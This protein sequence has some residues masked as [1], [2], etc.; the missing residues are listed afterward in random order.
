MCV[1]TQLP[2]DPGS[3]A[4]APGVSCPDRHNSTDVQVLLLHQIEQLASVWGALPEQIHAP[5]QGLLSACSHGPPGVIPLKCSRTYTAHST[6]LL[7]LWSPTYA[8]Q[9]WSVQSAYAWTQ[10]HCSVTQTAEAMGGVAVLQVAECMHLR[11]ASTQHRSSPGCWHSSCGITH[12]HS[13]CHDATRV[14]SSRHLVAYI[15]PH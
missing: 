8:V 9:W 10:E 5:Q 14:S 11:D 1:I 4:D 12:D 15:S 3:P 13:G 6:P 7:R 2:W